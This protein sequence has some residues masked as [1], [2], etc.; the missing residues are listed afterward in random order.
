MI[1]N[2]FQDL[3][4]YVTTAAGAGFVTSLILERINWF[5]NLE[6]GTKSF[7]SMVAT[8]IL[9]LIGYA[10]LRFIPTSILD[11]MAQWANVVLAIVVS[12]VAKEVTHTVDKA[13][14]K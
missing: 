5:Q 10:S 8:A 1:P 9:A 3:L 7:V 2:N 12:Y 13:S 14:G 11:E 6:S 4:Q